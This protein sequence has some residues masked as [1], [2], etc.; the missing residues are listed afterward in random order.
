MDGRRYNQIQMF[1]EKQARPNLFTFFSS[2]L[3]PWKQSL[4]N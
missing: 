3:S 1:L 2:T 4:T